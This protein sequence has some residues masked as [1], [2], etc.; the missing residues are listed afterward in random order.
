MQ[1]FESYGAL[2]DIHM[3][4]ASEGAAAIVFA[5]K[6]KYLESMVRDVLN[7]I[8][9]ESTPLAATQFAV[10]QIMQTINGRLDY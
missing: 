7:S 9:I 1:Q 10:F 5:L 6:V 3:D 2:Y 4:E 8:L